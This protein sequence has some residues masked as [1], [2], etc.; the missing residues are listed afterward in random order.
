MFRV[1]R[2]QMNYI[3]SRAGYQLSFGVCMLMVFL[4]FL[5]NVEAFRGWDTYMSFDPMKTLFLSSNNAYR[6]GDAMLWLVQ[7]YPVLVALAAGLTFS[8]QR[9]QGIRNVM[10]VRSGVRN[11]LI[12]TF[13]AVFTATFAVF[14][15]P[16][17]FEIVAN[18]IA[19]PVNSVGDQSMVW[20]Y[21]EEYRQ[22]LEHYLFRGVYEKSTVLYA[23]LGTVAFGIIS[24]LLGCLTAAISLVV[25]VRFRIIY[26][27]P[28]MLMLN[29][30]VRILPR[31]FPEFAG[32]TAWYNYM[33]IYDSAQKQSAAYFSAIGIMIVLIATASWYGLREDMLS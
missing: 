14:S 23:V 9:Q 25:K 31:L 13:G 20:A 5:K 16:F 6:S 3:C 8:V 10:V 32:N 18:C 1:F 19:F 21:G 28:V 15:V 22:M 2:K 26:L 27:L 29:G 24:G 11:Y 7:I 4:H 30:T 33:L 12:G 17:L